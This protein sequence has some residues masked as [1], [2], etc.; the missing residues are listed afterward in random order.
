[1]NFMNFP[2][3]PG[4]PGDQ[5]PIRRNVYVAGRR[6][7]VSME[8]VM[9]DSL[10]EIGEREG[11]TANQLCTLIDAKRRG[12]G[13]TAAIRVFII[14]YYRVLLLEAGQPAPPQPRRRSTMAKLSSLLAAALKAFG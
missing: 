13:L 12:A 9:W 1:M 8:P 5:A 2:T 14:S 7:S 3:D 6:T 11:M 10:K 4:M